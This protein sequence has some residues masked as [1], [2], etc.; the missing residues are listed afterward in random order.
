MATTATTTP[1]GRAI[2]DFTVNGARAI[3][4]DADEYLGQAHGIVTLASNALAEAIADG[5]A[6]VSQH[7]R[8]SAL[9]GVA[10]LIALGMQAHEVEIALGHQALMKATGRMAA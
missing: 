8:S 9:D 2:Q 10:T 5:R 6:T 4:L 7:A 3:D 1:A